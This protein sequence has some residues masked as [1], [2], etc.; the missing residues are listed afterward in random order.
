MSTFAGSADSGRK[1]LELWFDHPAEQWE[2]ALPLGN[3]QTAAMIFGGPKR[4]QYSLNDHHL[5]SGEPTSGNEGSPA[6]LERIRRAVLNADYAAADEL[7]RGMHGPYSARYL[8]LG[9]L[10]LNFSI[11]AAAVENYRRGLDLRT[12]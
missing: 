12:A 9:D 1:P 3:G 5:W 10:F 8:P 4:A 11:D 7:W 2:E 6:L